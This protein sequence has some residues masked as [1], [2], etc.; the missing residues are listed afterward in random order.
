MTA[1]LTTR[2]HSALNYR[3]RGSDTSD[4]NMIL[5]HNSSGEELF[6]IDLE[7]DSI[8]HKMAL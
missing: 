8:R 1:A 3:F 6:M 2:F 5:G 4:Y 7:G